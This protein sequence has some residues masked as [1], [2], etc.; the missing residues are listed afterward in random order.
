M[1]EPTFKQLQQ[2]YRLSHLLTNI[3][4]KPVTLVRI[5]RRNGDL[6]ILSGEEI[7]VSVDKQ[8]NVS[9]D[10]TGFQNDE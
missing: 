8:G 9:Y 1:D 5:D 7:D 4:L 3:F 10:Q 6:V 2:L